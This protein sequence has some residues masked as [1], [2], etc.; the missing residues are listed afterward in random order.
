M[1]TT[2]SKASYI[3]VLQMM[4]CVGQQSVE[5]KCIPSSFH[6]WTLPHF[7]GSSS[8]NTVVML[9]TRR[10]AS[11]LEFCRL[12]LTKAP[13]SCKQSLVKNMLA[14]FS[15]I[16]HFRHPFSL[17][18][19]ALLP[20]TWLSTCIISFTMPFRSFTLTSASLP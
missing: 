11:L 12:V 8:T 5:G 15:I 1:V 19:A 13:W 9:Q 17:A 10:V 14:S 3:F 16:M 2:G 6:H 18:Q 20:T 4:I 7:P